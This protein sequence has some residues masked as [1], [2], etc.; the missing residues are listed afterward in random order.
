MY[1]SDGAI[2]TTH[3]HA[4]PHC[5]TYKQ[6]NIAANRLSTDMSE[7][8]EECIIHGLKVVCQGSTL[9]L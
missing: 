9:C 1:E 3:E 6:V 8:D 2:D 7:I 4:I 5:D